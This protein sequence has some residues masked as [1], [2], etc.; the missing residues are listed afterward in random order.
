[1]RIRRRLSHYGIAGSSG[2]G[3]ATY[4]PSVGEGWSDFLNG[5]RVRERS[6][7][8]QVTVPTKTEIEFPPCALCPVP[9]LP[10]YPP[11]YPRNLKNNGPPRH[12]EAK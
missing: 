12:N 8:R 7:S 1:M 11:I 10:T 6:D 2:G 9:Y 3:G 5:F 4:E